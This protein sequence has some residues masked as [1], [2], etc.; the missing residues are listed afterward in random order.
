M[1]YIRSF[2]YPGEAARFF[3]GIISFNSIILR[4]NGSRAN[5][6]P[7]MKFIYQD[8]ITDNN[9]SQLLSERDERHKNINKQIEN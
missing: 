9:L 3:K 1:I 5:K 6:Y 7:E 8:E 2:E 4:L